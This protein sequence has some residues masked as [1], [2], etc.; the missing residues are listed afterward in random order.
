MLRFAYIKT[1]FVLP[2]RVGVFSYLIFFPLFALL[3]KKGEGGEVIERLGGYLA[4]S[5]G[6]TTT[7]AQFLRAEIPTDHR[8]RWDA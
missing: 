5:Q 4:F 8:S 1:A 6:Q 7:T 3:R 2:T